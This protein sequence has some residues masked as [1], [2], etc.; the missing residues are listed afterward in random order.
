MVIITVS[1]CLA[2]Q[3][4]G[5]SPS[6]LFPL[7]R[8]NNHVYILAKKFQYGIPGLMK[9]KDSSPLPQKFP[10]IYFLLVLQKSTQISHFHKFFSV[11]QQQYSIFFSMYRWMEQIRIITGCKEQLSTGWGERRWDTDIFILMSS[12]QRL[13]PLG[14]MIWIRKERKVVD[15]G[16]IH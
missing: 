15:Q 1:G 9:R 3:N 7:L 14:L 4:Q 5:H 11:V 10:N 6:S 2:I 8:N 13:K 12:V 16:L